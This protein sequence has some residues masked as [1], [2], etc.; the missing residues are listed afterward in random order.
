MLKG[1]WGS[2]WFGLFVVALVAGTGLAL[3]QPAFL[4]PF[5]L[6]VL[7]IS[8]SLWALVAMAQGAML[9]NQAGTAPAPAG[10]SGYQ[11]ASGQQ[12]GPTVSGF[13][14]L[15][16]FREDA[17][18]ADIMALLDQEGLA[19][20]DGPV[21]GMVQV[22]PEGELSDGAQQELVATLSANPIVRSVRPV[23]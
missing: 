2:D 5:N 10:D 15:I 6:Y 11:T 23:R 14:L 9:F 8:F 7:L 21:G 4:S 18:W 22:A 17:A 16:R 1:I 13:A 19:I 3:F 20:V 12:D